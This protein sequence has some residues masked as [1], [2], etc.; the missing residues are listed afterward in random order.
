[1]FKRVGFFHF[2][3]KHD[4]PIDCF[5][6]ELIQVP[7]QELIDALLVLPECIDIKEPYNLSENGAPFDPRF[8]EQIELISKDF[9]ISFVAGMRTEKD[10]GDILSSAYFVSPRGSIVMCHKRN[11]DKSGYY[12]PYDSED[13]EENN[14]V[15][16]NFTAVAAVIC[17]DVQNKYCYMIREAL[18]KM[19]LTQKVVCIPAHMSLDWFC[20]QNIGG[21][22]NGMTVILANSDPSGI[23]SFITDESGNKI[24]SFGGSKNK[25]VLFEAVTGEVT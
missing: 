17:M 12:R 10:P 3:A 15:I 19:E 4:Y 6:E 1:M 9:Q 13:E 25:I 11:N 22:W 8:R 21:H 24:R 23:D 16:F 2:G 7:R 14:P 18:V 20:I 5:Y